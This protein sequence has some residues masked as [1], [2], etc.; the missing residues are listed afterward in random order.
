MSQLAE[1]TPCMMQQDSSI[2][3]PPSMNI[4]PVP[5]EEE[6]TTAGKGGGQSLK[7]C[8]DSQVVKT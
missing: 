2:P 3:I 7:P 4:E 1:A 6:Q 8:P 5:Q